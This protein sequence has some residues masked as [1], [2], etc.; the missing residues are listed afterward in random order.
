MYN[1]F[2]HKAKGL[3]HQISVG[4]SLS[5]MG[6]I[7][8]WQSTERINQVPLDCGV[9]GQCLHIEDHV[10]YLA[11]F[12]D[13]LC[14]SFLHCNFRTPSNKSWGGGLG[15]RLSHYSKPIHVNAS[16]LL[17]KHCI[18]SLS[19]GVVCLVTSCCLCQ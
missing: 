9:R 8:N 7:T 14:S 4:L 3:E 12:Q 6:K 5:L 15:T 10:T 2:I 13:P 11:S 17:P 1:T 18:I 16:L 19:I